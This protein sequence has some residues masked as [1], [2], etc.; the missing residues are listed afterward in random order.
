MTTVLLGNDAPQMQHDGVSVPAGHLSQSVTRVDMR[1][2]FD[3]VDEVELALS[4]NNDRMLS[5]IGNSLKGDARR[6]A[7][8]ILEVESLLGVHAA[9]GSPAWVSSDDEEFAAVLGAHF[10]CPV[11]EPTAL[12]TTVGRDALHGQHVATAAQPA[13]FS[14]MAVANSA[15]ATAPAAGDTTLVG[16]ITTAGGGLLRAVGTVAH[17]AGTNTTTLSKTYT[18]NGSDSLPVTIS[19]IG[20]FN[21][22]S[23]GTLGYKTALNAN[24]TLTAVGDSTAITESVQAG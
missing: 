16:E 4:T 13:A 17:T 21:A 15:T 3:D 8:G 5:M 2:D 23:S 20:V 11:G 10:D 18:A 12:L 22:A 1:P 24:S 7:V 9:G 6:F 19:Q 14:F